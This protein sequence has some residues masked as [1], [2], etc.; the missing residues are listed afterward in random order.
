MQKEIFM[1]FRTFESGYEAEQFLETL[2][3]NGVI[4]ELEE[5]SKNTNPLMFNSLEK[6]ILIKL[7]QEDFE[8]ANEFVSE[9]EDINGLDKNYYLYSFTDEELIDILV[10]PNEWGQLDRKLAPKLLEK[11]GYDLNNLDIE[12]KKKDYIKELAKPQKESPILIIAGYIFALLGGLLGLAI[13][14]GLDNTKTTLP[15]GEKVFTYT[16]KCRKHG[17]KIFILA[18]IMIVVY[19]L[20]LVFNLLYI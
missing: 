8:K 6:E 9:D 16:E 2:E 14:W 20:L 12:S 10:K 7:R 1:P 3:K 5:Y 11:R 17:T 13:G 15:N 18:V 19:I 4:Y